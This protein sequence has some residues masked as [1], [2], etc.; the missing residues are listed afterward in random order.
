MY[1]AMERIGNRALKNGMLAQ[2][3]CFS[4]C[5]FAFQLTEFTVND[6]AA[7]LLGASA[8][9]RVYAAGIAC[10]AFGFASFSML[11]K[12]FKGETSQK[13]VQCA[14]GLLA[15]IA[16]QLVATTA[17][18]TVF[19]P[20]AFLSLLCL[21][22]IGGCVYY[23]YAMTFSGSRFSGRVAG[24]GMGCAVLLQYF[25]QN[26]LVTNAAFTSSVALSV[27]FLIYFA[28]RPPRDW[29]FEN[30]LPYS[31]DNRT[32]K[33]AALTLCAAVTLMSLIMGL[34]D[35]VVVERH[36]QGQLSVS[37]N[38]RL[39]YA[40]SLPAAGFAAD[41]DGRK[42]FPLAT[43]CMM[44]AS[45]VSNALLS[46]KSTFFFATAV[47]YV[48]AGFYVMFLT[49]AFLDFA[50]Q[51]GDPALWAGMGRILRGVVTALT[52]IPMPLLF[53]AF[54]SPTAVALGCALSVV[55]LLLLLKS[56][57][58]AFG[59]HTNAPAERRLFPE[60]ETVCAYAAACGMTPREAEVFEKLI[61]SEDGT[62]EI[63]NALFISRRVLQRYIAAIY[64]KTG[65]KSRVGLFQSYAVF[66]DAAK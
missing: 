23:N 49:V 37:A 5:F 50:P 13:V 57:T 10:T 59:A 61:T 51:T 24:V 35:G 55:T 60:K 45:T 19:L 22:N 62:Q 6:H 44:F 27:T 7:A 47:M 46:S 15:V 65:A 64:E 32:E 9:N 38:A 8:V 11:R 1:T 4:L 29:M 31:S 52:A 30:P 40:F 2:G 39:F 16:S 18:A 17:S 36:T 33:T 14:I 53:K 54:G 42:Y 26:L 41:W 3:L 12:L 20:A 48:Y 21:G 66:L 43:A 56:I 63:A 25:V 28:V 58:R 34:I